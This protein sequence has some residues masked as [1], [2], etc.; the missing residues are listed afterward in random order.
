MQKLLSHIRQTVISGLILLIP[1][2]VLLVLIQK[3]YR[4]MTGFGSKI[5]ELMGI[6]S[7]A[8]IGAAS[9][10]TSLIL[11]AM[12]YGSGLIVKIAF[13]TRFKDWLEES[14]LQYIPGYLT[15][16]TKM[17]EK[18]EKKTQPK[19]AILAKIYNGWRPGLLINR[20]A[21]NTVV[22]IPDSPETDKGEIWVLQDSDVKE[23]GLADKQFMTSLQQSGKGLAVDGLQLTVDG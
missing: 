5:S 17:L 6:K 11:V 15:Y 22:F 13:V 18:L 3:L 21:G 20:Q 23:I 9:I 4:S 8:G 10:A 7:I 2:F 12:F 19:T 1:V 16:R 14:L